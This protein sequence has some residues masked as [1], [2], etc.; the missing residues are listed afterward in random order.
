MPKLTDEA[1][2]NCNNTPICSECLKYTLEHLES[3]FWKCD[4]TCKIYCKK[5]EEINNEKKRI[6]SE[7]E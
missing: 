4:R 1:I 6:S 5:M 7:S 2:S 3:Y